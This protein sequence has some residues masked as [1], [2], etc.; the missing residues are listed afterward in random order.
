MM[1]RVLR[2]APRVALLLAGSV[3]GLIG[4]YA[5]AHS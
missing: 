4:A 1:K 2:S 5:I 3:V